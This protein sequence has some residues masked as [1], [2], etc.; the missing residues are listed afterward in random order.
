M[1]LIFLYLRFKARALKLYLLA[2]PI[3]VF[4]NLTTLQDALRPSSFKILQ[5][6]VLF[7]N[8]LVKFTQKF[9]ILKFGDPFLEIGDPQKGRDP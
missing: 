9:S 3:F 8:Y 2:T 4:R 5:K 6:G 1:F 7:G